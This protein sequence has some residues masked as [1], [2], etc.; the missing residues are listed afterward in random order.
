MIIKIKNKVNQL[1]SSQYVR[2]VA[3][4]ASGTTIAQLISLASA[5]IL[6]RIYSK[7]DYGTLGTYMAVTAVVGVFSTLRYNE[8]IMLEENETDAKAVLWLNRYLNLIFTFIIFII[9]LFASNFISENLENINLKKWLI[10]VPVSV[11]FSTNNNIFRVWANRN[12][13][14][15]VLTL[16]SIL[17]ALVI[18][19]FSI[20]Y[21]LINPN[22]SGLII[23][24]I[25]GQIVPFIILYYSLSKKYS[26]GFNTDISFN[27][28]L[29]LAKRYKNF[30]KYSLI[31]DFFFSFNS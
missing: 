25:L 8:A 27:K 14:Y 12:S 5:P 10:F 7:E 19:L 4:L 26:L 20:I 11:F 15:I 16:N 23:S 24:F 31:P 2:N 1:K 6:Y 28:L 17:V 30:P 9:F 22:E 3:T 29:L 13:E 18:P 21:G